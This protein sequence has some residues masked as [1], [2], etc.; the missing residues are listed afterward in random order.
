M[1]EVQCTHVTE[2]FTAFGEVGV[3]AEQVAG[4]AARACRRYLR[5]D[6]PV[7]EH[8]ADQ[9]LLPL[10]LAGSGAFRTM[11]LSSHATTQIELIRRFLDVPIR[12][13]AERDDVV[14]V[15]VG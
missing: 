4:R 3:R 13:I 10:A 12:V 9:L 5:S 8:L 14:R 7:G 2:L 6:A 1:L 15:E 11:P